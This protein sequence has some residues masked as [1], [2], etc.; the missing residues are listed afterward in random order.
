MIEP[1][2]SAEDSR[3]WDMWQRT[4]MVHAGTR[5]HRR[6]VDAA[7]TIMAAALECAPNLAVMWSGGKDS[8]AMTHLACVESGARLTVYSEKDDLDYPGELAYVTELGAQW[9]LDLKILVPPIS[10]SGWISKHGHKLSAE[11]PLQCATRAP[12]API[13]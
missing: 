11:I 6:R 8:T 3:L 13:R 9:G 5:L 1:I 10:P 12:G 2:L 7:R 4:A